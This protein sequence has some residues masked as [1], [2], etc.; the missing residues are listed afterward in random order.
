MSRSMCTMT[1][2]GGESMNRRTVVSFLLLIALWLAPRAAWAESKF[3]SPE[4]YF[5]HRAGAD[6]KLVKYAKIEAYFRKAAETTDR[7]KI[8]DL[9]LSSEGRKMVM[10]VIAAPETLKNLD[11]H[12]AVQRKLADP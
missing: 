9:G 11:A 1:R 3:P 8:Q 12:K 10:A 4:E 7:V 6:K 5:G 2:L